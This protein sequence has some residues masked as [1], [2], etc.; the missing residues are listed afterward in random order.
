MIEPIEEDIPMETKNN[1]DEDYAYEN[2]TYNDEETTTFTDPTRSSTPYSYEEPTEN[3]PLLSFKPSIENQRRQIKRS[4]IS[5]LYK[6][7][8]WEFDNSAELYLDDKFEIRNEKGRN[9]LYFIKNG[10][11][12]SLTKNNGEF[13]SQK[14]INKIINPS[15]Q[16]ILGLSKILDDT[17]TMIEMQTMTGEQIIESV[18][19]LSHNIATNTDLDMREILGIDKALTR[20]KGELVNNTSKLSEVDEQIKGTKEELKNALDPQE[21]KEL[22]ARLKE[23]QQERKVRLEIASQNQRQLSSQIARIR[24]TL[25]DFCEDDL[26]L[27]EKVKNI[28]REHGLTITA[29]VT[30]IGTIISTLVLSLT[31][32][33]GSGI[34]GGSP[35]NKPNT[36][37]EWVKNKLKALARLLGRLASKAAAALPG[38]LGSVL[39]AILNLLKKVALAAA[40]YTWI[41]LTSLGAYIGYE[42]YKYLNSSSKKKH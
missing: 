10:K 27:K 1:D 20:F 40:N 41:F 29:V 32:G 21:Q 9:Q 28:F 25:Y 42:T 5:D 39:A 24:D 15:E 14:T 30:A 19:T 6:H 8:K 2:E 36:G 34:P 23:L 3:H 17:P 33:G 7:M 22:K 26:S 12:Y 35:P 31:G 11:E 18:K 4:K 38:V 16:T 13:R 37:K